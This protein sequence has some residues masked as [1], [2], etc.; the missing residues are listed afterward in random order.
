[1]TQQPSEPSPLGFKHLTLEN[2]TE[3]DLVN[4]HF[5]RLSPL[6]GRVEMGQD[7]WARNFLAVDLSEDVPSEIRDLFAIARGA[8]LYGWFFYPLFRLGEE[9]L[10]R[11]L[12]TAAKL[13]YR[14]AGGT[15]N[16]PTYIEVIDSLIGLGFISADERERWTAARKLRNHASHPERAAVVPPGFALGMLNAIARDIAIPCSCGRQLDALV[17]LSSQPMISFGVASPAAIRSTIRTSV[18]GSAS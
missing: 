10:Y 5:V 1:M 8:M 7:D 17:R 9:Q 14:E 15:T 18:S 4:K 6:A 11:V 13:R 16:R 3:A 2:W 12:E